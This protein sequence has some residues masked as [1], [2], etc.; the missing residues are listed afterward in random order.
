MSLS[1]EDF[2]P[3]GRLHI[4]Y[5]NDFGDILEKPMGSGYSTL[6]A[7]HLACGALP[8]GRKDDSSGGRRTMTLFIDD[9]IR[10]AIQKGKILSFAGHSHPDNKA[11]NNLRQLPSS[12]FTAIYNKKPEE[13]DKCKEKLPGTLTISSKAD[14][15]S[16]CN[17]GMPW[18]V[19]HLVDLS[20]KQR[21]SWP[22]WSDSLPVAHS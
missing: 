8:L 7:K 13:Q 16:A 22:T 6:Y 21:G 10:G 15:I 2:G 14:F 20:R 19:L 12:T 9:T 1:C 18:P 5:S 11:I 3:F 4:A 17:G